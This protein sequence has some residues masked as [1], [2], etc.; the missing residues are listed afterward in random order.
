[1]TAASD[2]RTRAAAPRGAEREQTY[3]QQSSQ[4][5]A[6]LLF[7]LPL[8]VAYELG[9]RAYV[10]QERIIAFNLLQEFFAFFGAT[11]RFLPALA[12]AG[13]LLSWHIARSDRWRVHPGTLAGMGVESVA[14]G[15]PLIAVSAVSAYY[16]PL[17]TGQGDWRG[18]IVLSLG[19][20]IYEEL[21][22]RLVAFTLLHLLLIDVL[23]LP[24]LAGAGVVILASAML[25]SGYHYLGSEQFEWHSFVFRTSAGIYFGAIFLFRGFGVTA[26][27]HA[28]YDVI[29]VGLLLHAGVL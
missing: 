11:G 25:F 13:I 20:G 4:P 26:G 10:P 24:R 18:M 5:L 14:W 23:G 29:A 19:A 16:L 3:L 22:F 15:L 12:V 17:M 27:A 1:M 7:V 8:L 21:V 28:A 2:V 6:S 9:T